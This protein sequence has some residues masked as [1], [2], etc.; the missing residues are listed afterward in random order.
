MVRAA[1]SH[2]H[3][4]IIGPFQP[5][6]AEAEY[7]DFI[8]FVREQMIATLEDIRTGSRPVSSPLLRDAV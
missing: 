8:E 2:I 6:A 1:G 4:R 5:P 7:P 3:I